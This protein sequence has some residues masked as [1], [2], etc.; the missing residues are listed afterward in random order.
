MRPSVP[1]AF[2]HAAAEAA[3]GALLALTERSTSGRGQHVE[4]TAQRS[5]TACTQGFI[6][7]AALGASPVERMSGGLRMGS[8]QLQGVW[9]C[10][11]G[12]VHVMFLFGASIGPFTR[13]AHG[14]DLRG[15]LLRRRHPGQ[16]L[17]RLRKHAQR[18]AGAHR[19]VRT[20]HRGRGPVLRRTRP[21]P[22]CSTP[23]WTGSCSSR[24]SPRR[25]TCWTAPT[26]GSGSSS[27]RSTIELLSPEAIPAP[28]PWFHS[29]LVKPVRLGRAPRLGEHT[30]EV[31]DDL[32]DRRRASPVRRRPQPVV[33]PWRA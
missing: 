23:P 6:L 12:F 8:L 25:G 13:P 32:G 31:L 1:Q 4:V 20:G 24:R 9:P 21:K 17:A 18:R 11:D 15:G 5:M 33:R 7:A 27:S 10:Q 19:R 30:Q 28:G 14:M 26:F 16:G 3:G 22:S 2:L 29:S